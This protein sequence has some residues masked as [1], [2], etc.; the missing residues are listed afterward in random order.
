MYNPVQVIIPNDS[1]KCIEYSVK[2]EELNEIAKQVG[3][4]CVLWKDFETFYA[5]A[6]HTH[7][8]LYKYMQ[9]QSQP[10]SNYVAFQFRKD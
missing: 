9:V 6:Q 4:H 3:L 1:R 2:F 7:V 8:N 5:D 10:Q